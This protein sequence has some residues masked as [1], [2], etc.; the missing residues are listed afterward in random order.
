MFRTTTFS[1]LL[2]AVALSAGAQASAGEWIVKYR[3]DQ[4]TAKLNALNAQ[5]MDHNGLGRTVLVDFLGSNEMQKV[6]QL[7]R[8]PE[9]EYV[10]PN[11]RVYAFKNML[12]SSNQ[13]Q[14]QWSI[15]KTEAEKAWN[16]LQSR[17]SR[18]VTVAVIDTG[19]DAKHKNLASN[20]VKGWDFIKKT[21]NQQD[22]TSS[23]NPGH[24]THCGGIVGADGKVAGGIIGISPE[25]SIMP[26]RFLDENGSGDLNNAIKAIDFAIQKKV[27]IIS[28]SWGAAVARAGAKPLIEAIE[29]AE[30]AGILF[31]AAASNDGKNNDEYEVYPANAGVSNMITVAASGPT[32]NQPQWTNYGKSSVDISSPGEKI[33]STL[34]KDKWGN[35]SGTSM[36]TPMVAGLA[37]L[38]KSADPQLKPTEIKALLQASADSI[39]LETACD[40][41]INAGSAVDSVLD[42]KLVAVP[43]A[44]TLDPQETIQ[45]SA[46]Y[47][48][49]PFKFGV[50]DASIGSIDAQGLFTAKS[51]G[52]TR[53]SITDAKGRTATTYRIIVGRPDR[54]SGG[55]GGGECPLGNPILCAITC[56]FDPSA[57]WCE[58]G[59]GEE[60]GGGGFPFPWPLPLEASSGFRGPQSL[61]G[62]RL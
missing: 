11:I 34:P 44:A 42:R 46:L 52:E 48:E 5:V 30:K 17:G 62:Q 19:V 20:M 36:A 27:D 49:G 39:Q 26:L 1:R 31:V 51:K 9:V 43:H 2:L 18:S 15:A 54:G 4:V 28:A 7:L 8:S 47:G 6:T 56:M 21:E 41:R 61:P 3:T 25:V 33:L 16:R 59:G 32:D 37:A 55:G 24:G 57:P 23:K 13:L 45:F 14:Q 50:A 12:E 38:I 10:V 53:V 40:C 58:G 60:E 22:I 35:L 29:R